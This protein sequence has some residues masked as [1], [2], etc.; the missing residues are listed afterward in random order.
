MQNK[1]VIRTSPLTN[2]I[3]VGKIKKDIKS[4]LMVWKEKQDV[5]I[6]A[7]V[8]VAEHTIKFGKDVEI[9]DGEGKLLFRIKVESF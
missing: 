2:T 5:T 7:L 4:G 1:I 3:Y 6:E 8:A 9:T